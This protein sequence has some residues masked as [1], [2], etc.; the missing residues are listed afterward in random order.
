MEGSLKLFAG[1]PNRD[2]RRF[3]SPPRP[4]RLGPD[5]GIP[6]YVSLLGP[7]PNGLL[8]KLALGHTHAAR[9]PVQFVQRGLVESRREDLVHGFLT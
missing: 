4:E 6:C 3:P 2:G 8:Q 1:S 7:Q 5:I 9:D